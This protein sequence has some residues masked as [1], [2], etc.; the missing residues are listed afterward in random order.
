MSNFLH[1]TNRLRVFV[2]SLSPEQ[3]EMFIRYAWREIRRA[4]DEWHFHARIERWLAPALI[5]LSGITVTKNSATVGLTHANLEQLGGLNNPSLTVRQFR[6]ATVYSITASDVLKLASDAS[7]NNGS[8]TLNS[9]AGASA[10]EH[11]GLKVRV[12]GAGAAGAALD[13]TITTFISPTQVTVALAASTTV[14]AADAYIGSTLT[15]DDL[16]RETSSSNQTAMVY[17][18]LYTPV[19]T[20]FERLDHITDPI[21]GFQFGWEHGT[22]DELDSTDPRRGSV[23]QP[24]RVYHNSFNQTTGLPIYELWP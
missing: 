7:I 11:A 20:A 19:N 23:G 10:A 13:P 2:P 8:T 9:A 4:S 6:V 21:S 12:K 24:Y 3:A 22:L 17:R 15:L 5:T 16:Y 14:S 18:S 1:Y